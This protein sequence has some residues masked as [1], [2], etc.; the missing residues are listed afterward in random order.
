VSILPANV[1]D[2]HPALWRGAQLARSRGHTMETGY[3]KFSAELPGGGWPLGALVE[4]LIQQG[5]IGELRLLA[6]ALA[7]LGTRTIAMVQPPYVPNAPG[8]AHIGLSLDKMLLLRPKLSAD[9][10]W[11]AEQI[12]KAGSCGAL[13][14]WQQ[15]MRADSLRR[16]HLAAKASDM[17]FVLF[18]PLAIAG[19][20]SPAELRIA[21]R[22]S[23]E[24][25]SVDIVKRKGPRMDG[26]LTIELRPTPILL[27]PHGRVQWEMRPATRDAIPLRAEETT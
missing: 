5:G 27:S 21:L 16:L 14:F 2:I 23:A 8:L 18:R 10:L 22:P 7:S 1:E 11:T 13:L 24:G 15:H 9:A 12:L 3:A 26:P 25:V 19:D 17:L 20:P 4:I 6:P